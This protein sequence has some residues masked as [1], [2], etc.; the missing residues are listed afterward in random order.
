MGVCTAREIMSR[1]AFILKDD[2]NVRWTRSALLDYVNEAQAAI[3]RLVPSAY[4][5]RTTIS[6]NEG[7]RQKLP[8]GALSLLTVVRNVDEEGYPGNPVRLATRSLFDSMMDWHDAPECEYVEN[9]IFDDR[10]DTEF[11]VFPPNDGTGRV[12][13]V[14]SALPP[15]L[16]EWDPLSIGDEYAAVVTNYVLYKAALLDCDYNGTGAL[17]QF[18]YQQFLNELSGQT[19]ASSKAG[20]IPVHQSG[21]VAANG[22]TE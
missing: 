7:T 4:R 19:Q 22:G 9:Y 10:E 17:A 14:Y 5:V 20:P 6:L 16:D 1:A 15:T 2:D 13:V 11:D 3:V 12:E 21:P 18:Y 8:T